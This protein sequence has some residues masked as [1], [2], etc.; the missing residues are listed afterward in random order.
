M[1]TAVAGVAKGFTASFNGLSML[2]MAL[3][4]FAFAAISY[5]Q[6]T[7]LH[8]IAVGNGNTDA[9]SGTA[10]NKTNEQGEITDDEL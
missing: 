7:K 1:G 3:I 4:A 9:A 6:T 8:D 10:A 2:A 5:Q